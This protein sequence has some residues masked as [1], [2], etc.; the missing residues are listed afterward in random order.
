MQ[1]ASWSHARA[2]SV[3]RS[4]HSVLQLCWLK[5]ECGAGVLLVAIK[6]KSVGALTMVL[7]ARPYL[8]RATSSAVRCSRLLKAS[9]TRVTISNS[10]VACTNDVMQFRAEALEDSTD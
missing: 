1:E 8:D 2:Q 5:A 4:W 7:L 10:R 9:M 3:W 6:T